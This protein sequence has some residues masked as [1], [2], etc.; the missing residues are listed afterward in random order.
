MPAKK[1]IRMKKLALWKPAAKRR[2]K[3]ARQPWW[4]TT[5]A[6]AG[7]T[8]SV[9]LMA[10]LIAAYQSMEPGPAAPARTFA[11]ATPS[12][13]EPST[14]APVPKA[15]PS[16]EPAPADA[17]PAA[18][19]LTPVTITGCLERADEAFRLKD[20]EGD[21]APKA[22][23]WK[24]GFLKKGHTAVDLIDAGNHLNL[25]T[26]VGERV[27]VTGTLVEREFRVRTIQ[28]VAASCAIQPRV[29]V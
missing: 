24:S 12:H 6:L 28:R 8:V 4:R 18:A 20:T 14:P 11:A 16:A 22:R 7:A 3:S 23:S 9:M 29:K 17:P 2:R 15:A 13:V 25:S 27:T 1:A 10:V 26:H 21:D 5:P 19:T